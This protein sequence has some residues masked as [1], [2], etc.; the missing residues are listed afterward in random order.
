MSARSEL[1]AILKATCTAERFAVELADKP[2]LWWSYLNHVMTDAK[3]LAL[4]ADGNSGLVMRAYVGGY[5]IVDGVFS[6]LRSPQS[7]A[8]LVAGWDRSSVDSAVTNA[9]ANGLTVVRTLRIA[10]DVEEDV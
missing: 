5:G 4:Y 3:G 10:D 8:V 7:T 9:V 6:G 2:S 1:H